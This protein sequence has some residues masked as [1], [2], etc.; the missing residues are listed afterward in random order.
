MTAEN[1]I[2]L[3][4]VKV[5][6]TSLRD[7][8]EGFET[9]IF[10]SQSGDVL[11][12]FTRLM[13]SPNLRV[14]LSDNRSFPAK[15]LGT[16]PKSQISYLRTTATNVPFFELSRESS[17]PKPGDSV[18]GTTNRLGLLLASKPLESTKMSVLRIDEPG[19]HLTSKDRSFAEIVIEG[20]PDRPG[21]FGGALTNDAGELIGMIAGPE[22]GTSTSESTRRVIPILELRAAVANILEGKVKSESRSMIRDSGRGPQ[23]SDE[24][25]RGIVLLPE[26][27]D[28][29][30]PFVDSVVQ[31]SPA[32]QSGL[33]PDDLILYVGS[34][35][36]RSTDDLRLAFR[37]LSPAKPIILTLLR[38]DEL[39][40]IE[41]GESIPSL[42]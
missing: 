22:S 21:S 17:P 25:A 40:E 39:K 29:T 9:G 26:V 33:L 23:Q 31:G 14:V 20:C 1:D 37:P 11:T 6:G 4:T 16:D 38:G 15:L 32:H 24:T 8:V 7:S 42:K 30:P 18:W 34:A 35:I 3:R 27:L 28:Q 12:V 41:L 13:D 19:G 10:I 36:V 2:S 5:V